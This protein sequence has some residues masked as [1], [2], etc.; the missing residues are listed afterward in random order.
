M[1]VPNEDG[2][3][4]ADHVHRPLIFTEDGRVYFADHADHEGGYLIVRVWEFDARRGHWVSLGYRYY[5]HGHGF[6]AVAERTRSL[7][8]DGRPLPSAP[9]GNAETPRKRIRHGMDVTVRMRRFT[10]V[11]NSVR[12][13]LRD[14]DGRDVTTFYAHDDAGRL[15]YVTVR[16]TSRVEFD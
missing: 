15:V 8:L 16:D 4:L 13:D 3:I 5:K 11:T 7:F 10:R 12:H 2:V 6:T 14:E 1:M 9:D